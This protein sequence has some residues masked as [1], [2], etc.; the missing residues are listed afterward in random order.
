MG[1]KSIIDQLQY[2]VPALLHM[3]STGALPGDT[4]E[5]TVEQFDLAESC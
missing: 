2:K 5:Q 3:L 1:D 4:V